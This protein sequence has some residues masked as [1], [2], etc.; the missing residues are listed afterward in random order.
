MFYVHYVST[1]HVKISDVINFGLPSTQ[2]ALYA[3][4]LGLI[5]GMT[6]PTLEKSDGPNLLW[7]TPEPSAEQGMED[8]TGKH[9]MPEVINPRDSSPS[10][11]NRTTHPPMPLWDVE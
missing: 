1:P 10:G 9:W 4:F 3:S 6:S 11:E 7:S 8:R 2:G 5:T